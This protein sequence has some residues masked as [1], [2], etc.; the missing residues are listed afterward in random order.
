MRIGRREPQ[1][2]I[3]ISRADVPTVPRNTVIESAE[4]DGEDVQS[5][6]VDGLE[7]EEYDHV[8][9]RVIPVG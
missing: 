1:R 8:R 5:W 6:R 2:I 7:A 9:A 3:C 4:V